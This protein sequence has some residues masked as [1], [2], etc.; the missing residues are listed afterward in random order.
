MGLSFH[1]RRAILLTNIS[2]RNPDG[3]PGR[4]ARGLIGLLAGVLLVGTR[5]RV[6]ARAAGGGLAGA[7][8]RPSVYET[9]AICT[10]QRGTRR[11]NHV[12]Y[13]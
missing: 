6:R 11:M 8:S 12:M 7:A 9:R 2:T 10:S 5:G 3:R 1:I 13:F 4:P